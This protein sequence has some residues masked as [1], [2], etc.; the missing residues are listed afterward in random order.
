MYKGLYANHRSEGGTR[1]QRTVLRPFPHLRLQ[2]TLA[3]RA[4]GC[5][6][7]SR[8]RRDGST[9]E[10]PIEPDLRVMAQRSRRRRWNPFLGRPLLDPPSC[11]KLWGR[12]WAKFPS[13]SGAVTAALARRAPTSP[14]CEFGRGG[15]GRHRSVAGLRARSCTVTECH[16]SSPLRC[17]QTHRRWLRAHRASV[18]LLCAAAPRGPLD[19]RA[20]IAERRRSSSRA[21]QTQHQESATHQGR[22]V[23][24]HPSGA[25]AYHHRA[26]RARMREVQQEWNP[27]IVSQGRAA[28]DGKTL[29]IS[30]LFFRPAISSREKNDARSGS[31]PPTAL[32]LP[33]RRAAAP[34]SLFREVF[35]RP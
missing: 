15:R 22:S 20:S 25:P 5:A 26:G 8:H 30:S 9:A 24:G 1:L 32:S 7:A 34:S 14:I 29:R 17:P 21:H 28:T 35:R 33:R 13:L 12:W 18:R 10:S 2:E 31:H 11:A 6:R 19:H 3:A 27:T 4:G 23:R 16:P